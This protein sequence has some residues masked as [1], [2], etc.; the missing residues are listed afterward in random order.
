ME[1]RGRSPITI[2]NQSCAVMSL[3]ASSNIGLHSMPSSVTEEVVDEYVNGEAAGSVSNRRFK[4]SAVRSF[5]AFCNR[6]GLILGDPG[7][8]VGVKLHGLTHEQKEK[9]ERIPFTEDEIDRLLVEVCAS[10]W[11]KFAIITGRDTGLRLGDI[12]TI[13]WACFAKPGTVSV[14]TDKRDK[15]VELPL[16]PRM[17]GSML[18]IPRADV[19]YVFPDMAAR[20]NNASKRAGISMEFARI[21]KRC[22]IEGKS[23]HCL[24]HTYV[25]DCMM[26]GMPIEHIAVNVGHSHVETTK[27]YCH[28]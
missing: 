27:I 1:R 18:F 19:R 3:V 22:G 16:T 21:C 17:E 10:M 8:L 24:R 14:W 5:T 20:Y 15:R 9:K 4:L 26:K 25:T 23:F 2:H 7:R 6:S 13:E 11:W 28:A 12:C